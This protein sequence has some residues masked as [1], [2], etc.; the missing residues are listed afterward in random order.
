MALSNRTF[1][2]YSAKPSTVIT[3]IAF[4]D[5]CDE[6][7]K[8]SHDENVRKE[9]LGMESGEA[10]RRVLGALFD[11]LDMLYEEGHLEAHHD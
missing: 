5:W 9:F 10:R 4:A 3:N 7:Q 6:Y 8:D 11:Y 1:I 2:N